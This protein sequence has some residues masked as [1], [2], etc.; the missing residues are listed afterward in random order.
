[1]IDR[2]AVVIYGLRSGS[3]A[4][5]S[6]TDIHTGKFLE[7]TAVQGLYRHSPT[8]ISRVTLVRLNLIDADAAC[9]PVEHRG[10]HRTAAPEDLR[11]IQTKLGRNAMKLTA[12][13][14][15]AAMAVITGS[16]VTF[17]G[18]DDWKSV[19]VRVC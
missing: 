1:L 15:L 12:A 3:A 16:A 5:E 8:Y 7:Y 13:F 2:H 14:T 19:A 9:V 4:C 18:N 10:R 17:A 11:S 6:R